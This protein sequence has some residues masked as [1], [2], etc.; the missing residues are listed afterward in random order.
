M[1]L[2]MQGQD[3]KKEPS[4]TVVMTQGSPIHY[5]PSAWRAQGLEEPEGPPH[6]PPAWGMVMRLGG[7]LYS[8]FPAL[9]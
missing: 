5:I 3:G 7:L 1:V 8:P 2:K 4:Q 6:L 9:P